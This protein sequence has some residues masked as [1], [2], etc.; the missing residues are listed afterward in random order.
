ML[1]TTTMA[2]NA[3][4]KTTAD[5]STSRRLVDYAQLGIDE[6]GARH[7]IDWKTDTVHIVHADGARERKLLDAGDVDDYMAV[8]ADT[9]G[10]QRR[11][12]GI[13]LADLF[14]RAVEV[15]E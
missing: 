13:S 5:A 15:D 2:T 10:W 4:H 7:V 8:V 6:R 1:R 12:Y 9:Y 11:D 3:S 14:V